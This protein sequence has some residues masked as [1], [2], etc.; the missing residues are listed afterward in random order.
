MQPLHLIDEISHRVVNEYTEAICALGSSR[1]GVARQID[2]QLRAD[3][4]GEPA[5]RAGGSP[6]RAA[7]AARRPV[8]MNLADMSASSVAAWPRRH[9]PTMACGSRSAPTKSGSSRLAA[10]GSASFRCRTGRTRTPWVVWWPRRHLGRD[11]G[12]VPVASTAKSAMT[13]AARRPFEPAAAAVSCSDRRRAG[14]SVDWTSRRVAAASVSTSQ[15]R[16]PAESIC[17]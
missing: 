2:V 8:P 15:D 13:D 7:S 1:D 11:L 4:R 17:G 6:S 3:V 16:T 9:S 14:G 5:A 10:G 12:S